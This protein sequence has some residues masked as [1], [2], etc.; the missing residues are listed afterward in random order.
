MLNSLENVIRRWGQSGRARDSV[1]AGPSDQC[2]DFAQAERI[3]RGLEPATPELAQHIE[4]CEYCGKLVSDFA[5]ALAEGAPDLAQR[6]AGKPHRILVLR[7]A[8]LAVAASVLLA[9]GVAIF[10]PARRGPQ[11][12]LLVSAA[13]G[14]QSEIEQGL[15]P[16]GPATFATGDLIM[17]RIALNR[18]CWVAL[19]NLDP[20]GRLIPMLPDRSSPEPAVR[21]ERGEH[22]LGPY[23]VDDVVGK[24][25]AFIITAESKPAR[26]KER[27]DE[28]RKG[29]GDT[30][31]ARGI[32]EGICSWPAEVKAIS[33]DHVSRNQSGNRSGN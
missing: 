20:S 5:E 4:Q 29:F 16:K 6:A 23:L 31:D 22:L 13:V 18:D 2:L 12:P 3:A 27:I 10:F 14:L 17:L 11:A 15:T 33:F 8:G 19:L 26:I 7:L 24:E 30:G 21:F 1:P 9:V 25:T 32:T 28:L